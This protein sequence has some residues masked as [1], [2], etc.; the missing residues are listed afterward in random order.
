MSFKAILTV[1]GDEFTV[2]K[3]SYTISRGVD[4]LGRLTSS[5]VGGQITMEMESQKNNKFFEHICE[6]EKI[7]EGSVVFNKRHQDSKMRELKFKDAYIASFTETFDH[8]GYLGSMTMTVT[9][10]A[11]Y[12]EMEGADLGNEFFNYALN[13]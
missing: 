3:I 12:M 10:V 4:E 9:L 1:D 5:I 2:Y 8:S 7:K 11:K 6:S 13:K